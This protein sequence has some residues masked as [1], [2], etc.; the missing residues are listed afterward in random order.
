MEGLQASLYLARE[1][2]IFQ[3]KKTI[4]IFLGKLIQFTTPY[5]FRNKIKLRG[6]HAHDTHKEMIFL[7][8]SAMLLLYVFEFVL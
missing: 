7:L 3:K 8:I 1:S 5:F 4:N 6:V 2:K